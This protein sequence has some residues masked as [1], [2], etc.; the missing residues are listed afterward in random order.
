M[1][2]FRNQPIRHNHFLWWPRLLMDQDKMSNIYSG[3][4]IDTSY[5]DS[6]HLAKRFQRRIFFRNRQITNKNCLWWPYLS[7][8]QDEISNLNRGSPIDDS[9]EVS[10]HLANWFQRRISLKISQSE[11]KNHLW[12]PCL[13]TSPDEKG[14][15]YMGPVIDASYQVLVDAAKRFQRRRNLEISQS[16]TS[17]SSGG[18]LVN[19]SGQNE[20]FL[21]RT[22]NICFLPRFGSFGQ[23][24]SA[25]KIFQKSANRKQ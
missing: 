24:I 16:D 5:Q 12:W 19:G 13:L 2:F 23:A 1:F 25:G 18:T 8:D 4:S 3:P 9:C 10:V 14:N 22:F 7:I 17:I 20:Q 6:V 11:K 21:Q 15:F